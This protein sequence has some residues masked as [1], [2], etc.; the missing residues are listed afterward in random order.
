MSKNLLIT[1]C[2]SI[3]FK[4]TVVILILKGFFFLSIYGQIFSSNGYVRHNTDVDTNHK[5]DIRTLQGRLLVFPSGVLI[6]NI[7]MILTINDS[8]TCNNVA[9]GVKGEFSLQTNYNGIGTISISFSDQNFSNWTPYYPIDIKGV[10][11]NN[12][13]VNLGIIPLIVDTFGYYEEWGV[14][15]ENKFFKRKKNYWTRSIYDM[16]NRIKIEDELNTIYNR[17]CKDCYPIFI[18]ESY[19][20]DNRKTMSSWEVRKFV[21]D[22]HELMLISEYFNSNTNNRK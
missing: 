16:E 11:F 22:Y 2:P 4:W 6:D 7:D 19:E 5:V 3:Y 17:I 1:N 10:S 12:D 9:I 15:Q 18:T 8:L 20:D 13:T 21:I 14:I